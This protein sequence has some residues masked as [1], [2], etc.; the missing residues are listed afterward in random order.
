MS[1]ALLIYERYR[2]DYLL[3]PVI[4]KAFVEESKLA[5]LQDQRY[6]I[7]LRCKQYHPFD[8]MPYYVMVFFSRKDGTSPAEFESAFE[9]MMP[10]IAKHTAKTFPVSHTRHYIKRSEEGDCPAEVAVG[11]QEEFK[12]D[13]VSLIEFEDKES[14]DKFR[15]DRHSSEYLKH[16]DEENSANLPDRSTMRAVVLSNVYVTKGADFK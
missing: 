13:T 5:I 12:F 6:P 16:F 1:N 3:P 8:K 4:Y 14:V 9:N 10:T 15:E 7:G 11:T 2:H